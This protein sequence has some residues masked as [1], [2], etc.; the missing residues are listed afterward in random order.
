MPN[1][2]WFEYVLV[3]TV[4]VHV[5]VSANM[6]IRTHTHTSH[7]SFSCS[8][9]CAQCLMNS[10]VH[11]STGHIHISIQACMHMHARIH[12]RMYACTHA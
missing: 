4:Y 5:S 10:K 2:G 7:T 8:G 12:A 9:M 3:H 11:R 1:M 6:Y